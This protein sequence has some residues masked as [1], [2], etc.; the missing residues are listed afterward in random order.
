[1]TGTQRF[2]R[3]RVEGLALVDVNDGDKILKMDVALSNV[4]QALL[5]RE[6]EIAKKTELFSSTSKNKTH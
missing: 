1:M 4:E 3:I 2:I 5:K 6:T